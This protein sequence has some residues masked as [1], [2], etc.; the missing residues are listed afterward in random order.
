MEV[1]SRRGCQCQVAY[2]VPPAPRSGQ[3]GPG[4]GECSPKSPVGNSPRRAR[5][6]RPLH[7]FDSTGRWS[8]HWLKGL[9]FQSAALRYVTNT[10]ALQ[11]ASTSGPS[12]IVSIHSTRIALAY[13]VPAFQLNIHRTSRQRQQQ[14]HPVIP[15]IILSPLLSRSNQSIKVCSDLIS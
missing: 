12:S 7:L 3:D 13:S 9:A 1:P 6:T 8:V 11:S 15:I 5:F 10:E 4:P 2:L 14:Q